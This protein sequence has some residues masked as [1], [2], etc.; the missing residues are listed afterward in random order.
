MQATGSIGKHL[1]AALLA[2][3]KH[4]ITIIARPG[5]ASTYPEGSKVVRIDYPSDEI[6]ALTDVLRGQDALIVTM[7]VTAPRDT[8]SK[9][10]RAAAAAGVPYIFPNWYGHDSSNDDLCDDSLLSPIRDAIVGEITSLGVSKY[11]LLVCNFSYEFS[12]AGGPDRFGFDFHKNTL[13]LHDQGDVAINTTTWAQC[14]RAAASLLSLKRLPDDENDK[15][16]TL[17]QFENKPLFVS[18]FS[19]SQRDMFESVKRVLN[20]TDADWTITREPAKQRWE[21]GMALVKQ[22]NFADF[23]KMLYSRMFFKDGGGDY[24]SKCDLANGVLGLPVEDLDE[25]TR[26]GVRM[27]RAGEV[28]WGH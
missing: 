21:D 16:S 2:T 1:T 10:I 12:L 23:T 20:T 3:G 7:A 4:N 24:Q 19:I 25:A 15:A 8:I 17:A 28:P 27:A 22:G 11:F 18:S 14:G 13:M 9:F 5:S 26:E 6:S